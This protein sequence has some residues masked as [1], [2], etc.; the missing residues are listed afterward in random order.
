MS[1]ILSPVNAAIARWRTSLPEA[2]FEQRVF[3]LWI[4]R[5]KPN[6]PGRYDKIP[7]YASGEQRRGANGS[8]EDRAQL[9]DLGD[10]LAAFHRGRYDGIGVALLP[11]APFWALDLDSCIDADMFSAL[12][13]R[14]IDCGTYCER[15][16][17][18][19]GLRA[20]FAGKA[21]IDAKNYGRGVEV[22][23]SRGFVTITGERLA[24]E[25]LL[26]CPPALLAEI[27]A[28]VGVERSR[29]ARLV[30]HGFTDAPPENAALLKDV[31]LPSHVW[32]RLVSPYAPGCDRSAAALSIALQLRQHGVT[33]EQALELCSIPE[34]LVPALERRGGDIESARAW[35]W[36]YCVVP[37][38]QEERFASG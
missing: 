37:A 18:G 7:R 2:L 28:I 14:V 24:G 23:D 33:R 29:A 3:L 25:S 8:A 31:R 20:L 13:Q 15:S 19:S 17:S 12:A 6:K 22:F 11:D 36:K 1:V 32:R 35:M 4:R 38:Y 26:P 21:G 10:A 34:M 27:L 5:A 30:H 16:P 9:V